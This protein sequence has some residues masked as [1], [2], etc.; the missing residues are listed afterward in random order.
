MTDTLLKS[1]TPFMADFR[2][3]Q[4]YWQSTDT[5]ET[6]RKRATRRRWVRE[7]SKKVWLE[8]KKSGKAWKVDRFIVLIG[9]QYPKGSRLEPLQA[10][11]TVKPVIDAGTDRKLW[12]D[13]DAF[14]RHATIYYRYPQPEREGWVGLHLMVV[15]VPR[16]YQNM[17]EL[18]FWATDEWGRENKPRPVEADGFIADFYVPH[19][20]WLTSNF[21][22]TDLYARQHG[23]KK[24]SQHWGTGQYTGIRRMLADRLQKASMEQWSY[25]K[26]T[27][28][29]ESIGKFIALVGVQ[30]PSSNVSDPDNASETIVNLL[31]AGQLSGALWEAGSSSC[32]AVSIYK[33]PGL[34]RIPYNY[35]PDTHYVQMLILPIPQHFQII[36]AGVYTAQQAWLR[37]GKV[38]TAA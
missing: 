9:V 28:H 8:R 14:H 32:H 1:Q 33:L 17:S 12:V 21:T 22:D 13:D 24:S 5:V 30:Y 35:E 29:M 3:P 16:D 25:V 2:I 20:L 15:P 4:E 11:E 6:E 26:R 10:A 7:Y 19:K 37:Q 36:E 31:K 34:A 18:A 27:Q 38:R 23:L